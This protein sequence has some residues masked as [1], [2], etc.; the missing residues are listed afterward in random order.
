MG[1]SKIYCL[2][3]ILL[4]VF[5]MAGCVEK[6]QEVLREEQQ[7]RVRNLSD[8]CDS[9]VQKACKEVVKEK[10][11]LWDVYGCHCANK[12]PPNHKQIWR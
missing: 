1:N 10:N 4:A 8:R 3:T 11:I 7:A 5:A 6:S 2:A 9:G 12:R